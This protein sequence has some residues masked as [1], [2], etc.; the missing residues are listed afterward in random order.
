MQKHF[1][2]VIYQVD[3]AGS[4]Y[5]I[6]SVHKSKKESTTSTC[7]VTVPPPSVSIYILQN[8]PYILL[9]VCTLDKTF[10]FSSKGATTA[11]PLTILQLLPTLL[12]HITQE[13]MCLLLQTKN[14]SGHQMAK[15]L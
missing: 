13:Y 7:I 2:D 12:I 14:K 3:P 8:Y 5:H 1:N 10:L 6:S 15:K 9:H 11:L 4:I